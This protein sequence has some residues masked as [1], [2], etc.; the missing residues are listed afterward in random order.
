MTATQQN[1]IS[2]AKSNPYVEMCEEADSQHNKKINL[3]IKNAAFN[4][5]DFSDKQL[6]IHLEKDDGEMNLLNNNNDEVNMTI[7]LHKNNV[8]KQSPES[9]NNSAMQDDKQNYDT[10]INLGSEKNG[11]IGKKRVRNEISIGE[12]DGYADTS[13]SGQQGGI[14]EQ[15]KSTGIR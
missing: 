11:V 7:P 12:M 9:L 5:N 8:G 3:V 14:I 1:H 10:V 13:F 15:R 4:A 6:E 2:K